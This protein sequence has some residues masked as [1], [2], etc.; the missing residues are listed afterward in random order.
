MATTVRK[1]A[2]ISVFPRRDDPTADCV[3]HQLLADAP[4]RGEVPWPEGFDGG[5]AHRL[6][7]ST[8]GALL[9]A[10]TVEELVTFRRWFADKRFRKVYRLLGAKAVSW[11]TNRC[12]RAIAHDK[13]RKR[14]MVV[15]RGANTPHRGRWYPAKTDFRRL[16]GG[17]FEAT[18]QTGVMHQIRAH[19]AFVGIA[20]AG[21]GL[22]GGGPTPAW[23]P[24]GTRFGV[25]AFDL[26]NDGRWGEMVRLRNGRIEGVPL[27]EATRAQ[28]LV[29]PDGD[30]VGVARA[31]GIELG[32]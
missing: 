13:R 24:A 19:A 2:G 26:V 4:W 5:I 32:A 12:D 11:D 30:L 9:V 16:E 25:G 21:D 18:M 29:D 17:L 10:D 20:L 3:L 8:S 23:F 22:Y 28:K 1:S 6:D 15:Q 27:A 14:R 31:V 7:I